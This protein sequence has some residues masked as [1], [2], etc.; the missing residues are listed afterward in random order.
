[1]AGGL[2]PAARAGVRKIADTST[3]RTL[4]SPGVRFLE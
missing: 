1:M 4:A 2:L 3:L